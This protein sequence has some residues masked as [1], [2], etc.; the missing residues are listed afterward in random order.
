MKSYTMSNSAL[1]TVPDAARTKTLVDDLRAAGF[2]REDISII[3]PDRAGV[4]DHLF[5]W[6]SG[7]GILVIPGMGTYIASGPLLGNLQPYKNELAHGVS[8]SLGAMGLSA[9]ESKQC[10]NHLRAGQALVAVL[11]DGAV[12]TTR[13]IELFER[14]HAE[15]MGVA[16]VSNREAAS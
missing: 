7:M 8:R 15:S 12:E 2:P 13:A 1:C 9:F 16:S 10:E 5:G 6:L 3:L 14:H 11:V 4:R